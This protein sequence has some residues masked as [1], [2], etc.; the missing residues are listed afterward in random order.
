MLLSGYLLDTHTAVAR[1]VAS[2]FRVNRGS[3]PLLVCATAHPAKF[4][5]EV[6]RGATGTAVDG[7]EAPK[8][9]FCRLELLSRRPMMHSRLHKAIGTSG[10]PHAV[11]PASKEAIVASITELLGQ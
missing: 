11:L 1:A 10:A 9:L 4:A 6:L 8:E 2:K 5:A 3:V 7:V